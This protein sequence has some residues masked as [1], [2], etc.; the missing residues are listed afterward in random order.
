M[1]LWTIED[2][3]DNGKLYGVYDANAADDAY[4]QCLQELT[5]VP[6]DGD[7]FRCFAG[8]ISFR[9]EDEP[10]DKIGSQ[11]Q[12]M[13]VAT[14]PELTPKEVITEE[15]IEYSGHIT[16]DTIETGTIETVN[17]PETET[18]TEDED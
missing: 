14:L 5:R 3:E 9:Y 7:I 8:V 11:V 13:D 18:E 6:K 4:N 17:E 2:M 15:K 1:A 12:S 16:T 10:A